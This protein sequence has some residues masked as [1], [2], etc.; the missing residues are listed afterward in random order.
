MNILPIIICNLIPIHKFEKGLLT[1]LSLYVAFT[2]TIALR[3]GAEHTVLIP[4]TR[5]RLGSSNGVNILGQGIST[6]ATRR[7]VAKKKARDLSSG[8]IE[9]VSARSDEVTLRLVLA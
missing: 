2:V 4:T 3:V 7:A 1:S 5:S 8:S 9:R 6:R